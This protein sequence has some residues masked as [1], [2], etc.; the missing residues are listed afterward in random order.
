MANSFLDMI[1]HMKQRLWRAETVP[2]TAIQEAEKHLIVM[3]PEYTGTYRESVEA[4]PVGDEGA[5]SLQVS[6]AKL[7][8]VAGKNDLNFDDEGGEVAVS[9]RD[10]VYDVAHPRFGKSG[11]PEGPY[12]L[13]IEASGRL[14]DEQPTGEGAWHTIAGATGIF[15]KQRLARIAKGQT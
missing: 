10:Y 14:L 8:E 13:R 1:E 9:A 7:I 6:E 15:I 2:Q 3:L 12:P 4:V 5:W 11:S